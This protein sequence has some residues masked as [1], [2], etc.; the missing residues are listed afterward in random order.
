MT[1][2]FH[3]FNRSKPI[4]FQFFILILHDELVHRLLAG[5]WR[6][7]GQIRGREREREWKKGLVIWVGQGRGLKER[8]LLG[9]YQELDKTGLEERRQ[10]QL[11]RKGFFSFGGD[12]LLVGYGRRWRKYLT[13]T[14]HTL[15]KKKAMS[16]RIQTFDFLVTLFSF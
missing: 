14:K 1:S 12:F 2:R 16:S 6:F 13:P 4:S 10:A 7:L 9:V 11:S 5:Y 8:L 3:S 15:M